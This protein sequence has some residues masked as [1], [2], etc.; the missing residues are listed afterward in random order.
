MRAL[1]ITGIAAMLASLAFAVAIPPVEAIPIFAQRY[2]LTCADCHTAVPELNAFGNAFRN[3][4]YQLPRT[5]ARHGT[6]IVALR[7]NMDYE[8]QPAPGTRRFSP[9]ASILA[10]AD[11]G[12]VNVFLHYNLGAGGAAGAPFLGFLSTY[13][14]HTKSLYRAGLYELPLTQSAGQRLDSIS[15]YG[16]FGTSVGQ[17]D[18]DLNAPRLGFEAERVAGVARIAATFALGEFKGAAYGGKPVFTGASTTAARPEIGLYA[19][20]PLGHSRISLNAQALDGERNIQLP[21]RGPFADT[22]ERFGYGLDARVFNERLDFTLQQW[23]GH[24]ADTD[25]AGGALGST[26]GYARLKYF[27]TPHF[28][29][30]ARY[31]AAANPFAKRTLVVYAGALVAKHARVVVEERSNLLG[32]PSTLGGYFTV[33]VPWPAGL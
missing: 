5:T 9:A 32:G 13:N 3:A 8:V 7:Y 19:A 1:S 20:L 29:A 31:D 24:D 27:I 21:G 15:T 30:A 22:Y 33:A 17:N 10:N 28:Y 4:G 16:Y 2:A 26:G 23:L 14:V 25:G 6:T 18:L 11:V 12:R